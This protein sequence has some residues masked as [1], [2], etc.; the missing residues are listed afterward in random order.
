MSDKKTSEEMAQEYLD[1]TDCTTLEQDFEKL[2]KLIDQVRD[3]AIEECA[4]IVMQTLIVIYDGKEP[5]A[6]QARDS[7][8]LRIRKLKSKGEAK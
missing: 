1:T 5:T 7:I 8:E 3:E 4:N 6:Q 2:V